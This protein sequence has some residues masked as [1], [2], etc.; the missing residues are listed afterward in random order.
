[1]VDII[2]KTE[3]IDVSFEYDTSFMDDMDAQSLLSDWAGLV[4]GIVG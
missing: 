2:V 4:S 3:T 1:M